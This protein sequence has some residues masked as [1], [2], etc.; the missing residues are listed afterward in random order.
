[1]ET[2]R[3]KQEYKTLKDFIK[4]L[5]FYANYEVEEAGVNEVAKALDMAPSKVSRMLGTLSDEGLFEKNRWTGKYR[6]GVGFFEIGLIY[7]SNSPL[8]K[9]LRPHIEQIA[10][11]T[12]LVASWAILHKTR[13]IVIDRVDNMNIDLLTSRVGLNLPLHTTSLG[14]VLLANLPEENLSSILNA[15]DLTKF[16]ANSI[17]DMSALR[18][19]LKLVRQEGFAL[20]QGETHEDLHCLSAP[21]MGS[22][23]EV[24]AG[25]CAMADNRHTNHEKILEYVDYIKE[26]ALFISR[27]LGYSLRF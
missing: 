10:K 8:R 15:V 27:Q 2:S 12:G 22:N 18:D 19:H 3:N 25:I 9:I 17:T 1:M 20:D 21:V 4:L 7:I 16:T 24:V 14:K 13:A 6:I 26:K 11:E 5:S 23:G